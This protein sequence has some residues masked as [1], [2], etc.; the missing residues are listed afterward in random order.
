MLKAT[1]K[2]NF[3]LEQH[4]QGADDRRTE[5]EKMLGEYRK[6]RDEAVSNKKKEHMALAT[7]YISTKT[8]MA[9]ASS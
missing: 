9:F 6:M 8:T 7:N 3:D 1:Y 5:I 4:T 2:W